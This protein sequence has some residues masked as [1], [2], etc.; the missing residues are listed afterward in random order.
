MP[1]TIP[2]TRTSVNGTATRSSLLVA[3][4]VVLLTMVPACQETTQTAPTASSPAGSEKTT[5]ATRKPEPRLE[6]ENAMTEEA[7]E[8]LQ[9]TEAEWKERLTREEYRILRKKGTERPFTGEFHDSKKDGMYTCAG[10]GQ[11]LFDSKT[12]FDSGTGWPSFYDPADK[13]AVDS[14]EDR[15]LFTTRTEVLCSRCDGHLG[16]VFNDGPAPTGLRYCING[17]SLDF[18]GRNENAEP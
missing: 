2:T 12:K 18:K 13:E 17:V 16:H 15:S 7:R 5:T 4:V 10:C 8:K 3:A 6:G 9:L 14:E 11:E 1:G